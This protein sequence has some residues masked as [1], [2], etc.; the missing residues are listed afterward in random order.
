MIV[1]GIVK[2]ITVEKRQSEFIS[3]TEL[4]FPV[5]YKLTFYNTNVESI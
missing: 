2:F 4:E 3:D 5:S 1:P